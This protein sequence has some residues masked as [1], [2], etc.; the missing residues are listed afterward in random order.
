MQKYRTTLFLF[1]AIY[2]TVISCNKKEES[3]QQPPEDPNWPTEDTRTVKS[4][5]NFPW[6]ILWGQDNHIWMTERNG[7]IS[8]IDPLN[9]NTVFSYSITDVDAQGEGGLLGMVQHPDFKNNGQFFVVYNYTR[10]GNYT[11]KVVRFTFSNNAITNPVTIID[12]IPAA[13]IHNG[14]RLV[15]SNETSPKLYISTGDANQ[16][17]KAQDQN[18]LS[19][20][21]LRLNLDGSVPSDNPKSGNPFW[22]FGHRN[23]QGLVMKNNILYSSEHGPNTEDEINI[24]E[25]GRNY[26]W[27]NVTGPCDYPDEISFCTPNNVKIPTWST[28]N[29]TLATSGIDYYN[30]DRIPQWKNSL[31]LVTLK[32]A[33]LYQ[34]QLSANGQTIT[35]S[36]PYFKNSW[37]RLRDVCVSPAGRVY[38][39]TSNGGNNDSL[40]EI[41][42]PD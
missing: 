11:E 2:I 4:R 42:K 40:I 30:A 18:S 5:L 32:D 3:N 25:K 24:I 20:K 10:N 34:L 9:G 16:T 26:G 33:T 23:P 15:I 35:G 1:F 19:G 39:C 8:K 28:G 6:E 12:N 27:P 29:V 37:G 14:S 17:V 7:K 22:T 21:I 38:I 36:K 41:Q 31:L 13:G